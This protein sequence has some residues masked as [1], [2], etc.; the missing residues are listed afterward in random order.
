MENEKK[1]KQDIKEAVKLLQ[2]YNRWR[3]GADIEMPRPKEIG[4]AID[5]AIE[6][7]KK[8]EKLE[9]I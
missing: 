2:H 9:E 3:R 1:K 5:T 8:N 7:I 6:Y 4:K